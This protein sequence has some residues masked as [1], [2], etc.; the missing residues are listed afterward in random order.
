M[1]QVFRAAR[2]L[3]MFFSNSSF[4]ALC[5]AARIPYAAGGLQQVVEL[6]CK[7]LENSKLARPC[8]DAKIG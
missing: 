8:Q 5:G 1:D 2:C 4:R 6:D 3:L 7:N